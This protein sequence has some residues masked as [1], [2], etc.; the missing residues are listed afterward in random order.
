ME[1]I[2]VIKD[3]ITHASNETPV[4]TLVTPALWSFQVGE[5]IDV[6]VGWDAWIPQERV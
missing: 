3:L 2:H 6:V 5:H 1:L 4:K